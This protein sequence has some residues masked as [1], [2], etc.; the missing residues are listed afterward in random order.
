MIKY[1]IS[2]AIKSYGYAYDQGALVMLTSGDKSWSPY[3]TGALTGLLIVMTTWFTGL[4]FGASTSFVRAAGYIE[5]IFSPEHVSSTAYFRWFP[6]IFDWQFLFVISIFFG[7][8]LASITSGSFKLQAVP[9]M[10]KLR[11]GPRGLKRGVVA[12]FGGVIALIGARMAGGCPSGFGLG[13]LV[14]LGLSGL[15]AFICFFIG[16]I[17]VAKILYHQE[18]SK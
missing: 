18:G 14:Q 2:F 10:W 6:P 8:F 12:F 11:F 15:I 3:V 17:V 9:D 5:R 7:S 4:Y 13:A 16:G 1:N